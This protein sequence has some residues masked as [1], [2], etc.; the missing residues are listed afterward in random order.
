M[1]DLNELND[2]NDLKDLNDLIDLNNLVHP[3]TSPLTAH[4]PGDGIL[5]QGVA[6]HCGG[7]SFIGPFAKV[8]PQ[9]GP[10]PQA[11]KQWALVC[12]G[13]SLTLKH[14]LDGAWA[15]ACMC[16]P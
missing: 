12:L 9:V 8:R 3:T 15:H 1:N 5:P 6:R 2:L 4:C 7:W 11:T 13:G 14:A 10:P 16:C